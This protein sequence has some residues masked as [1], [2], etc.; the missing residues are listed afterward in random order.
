MFVVS[1]LDGTLL[2]K[3]TPLSELNR[4]SFKRVRDLGGIS[5]IATGRSLLG[6]TEAIEPE[7]PIDYLIFSSGAGI[8]DW[9]KKTLLHQHSL[10]A[11]Q[12]ERVF[13]YLE[14]FSP[15]EFPL[16]YVIQLGCPDTHR[17]LFTAENLANPD[18]VSRLKLH[19]VHGSP[20]QKESLPEVASEFIVIQSASRGPDTFERIKR[21]LGKEFNIVRATSPIDGESVWIEVFHEQA[22]KANAA[23]WI[24]KRHLVPIENTC[25]LGNDYNDLQ[26]LAWAENP[27]VV[28]D[29]V[30][31]LLSQFEAVNHHSNSALAHALELWL[32]KLSGK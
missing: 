1:D 30:P 9:Q 2:S 4:Q 15:N 8:Y 5:A 12:I 24:R 20:L 28:G 14:S 6:V 11:F 17:F 10:D 16:D 7:F 19:K 32:E 26:L 27:F 21:E 29:A 18:F 23:D 13:N 31:E 25:A 3:E 22:S